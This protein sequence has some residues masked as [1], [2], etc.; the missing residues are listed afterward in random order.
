MRI[1]RKH[2]FLVTLILSLTL[3]SVQVS[4][5]FPET[6]RDRLEKGQRANI[7]LIGIDARPGEINARSDTIILLSMDRKMGRA[8]LVSIP[9]DTRIVLQGRH[10]KIN[11]INQLKGPE[12]LCE[13][14][15]QMMASPVEYY[16]QTNFQ[17]FEESIDLIGGVYIDV[18]IEFQSPSS[19]IYLHKGYQKLSGKEALKYVR[20]RGGQDADI[21]RTQRQ[22]RLIKALAE[23]MHK[24]ENLARLPSLIPQLRQNVHTNL[25]WSDLLY[26]AGIAEQFNNDNLI[27]QTL[28]GYHYFSPYSGASF[29]EADREIAASLLD[30]LYQGHQF[31]VHLEAPPW[32]QQW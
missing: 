6:I 31:E 9:R 21:G 32:V 8:V 17:G 2:G 23:Q 19:G 27:T 29:W 7:L 18:D 3:I 25:G 30:S 5:L 13:A 24:K 14:I 11:M 22:Q 4:Q 12:A 16:I 28:P 10:T 1:P 15:S 20:F 26:L